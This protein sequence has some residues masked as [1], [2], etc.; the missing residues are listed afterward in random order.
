M[1]LSLKYSDDDNLSFKIVLFRQTFNKE[2][3]LKINILYDETQKEKFGSGTSNLIIKYH[4]RRL[5]FLTWFF[6]LFQGTM[7]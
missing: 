4:R 5:R 2:K 1:I 7:Q 3:I 6:L